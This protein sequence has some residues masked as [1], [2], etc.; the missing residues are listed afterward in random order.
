MGIVSNGCSTIVGEEL[1]EG[2]TEGGD[3]LCHWADDVD[4][5]DVREHLVQTL[6]RPQVD[7]C[8]QQVK[9]VL[10]KCNKKWW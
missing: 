2:G 4:E 6:Q 7:V 3:D 8:L 10:Y 1:V 9:L 5:T